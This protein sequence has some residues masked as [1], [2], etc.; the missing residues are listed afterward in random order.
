MAIATGGSVFNDEADLHKLDDV[1]D[2]D[3]G[4]AGEVVVT[5]DDTLIMKVQ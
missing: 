5:K 3:L 2:H 4:S 1:Q